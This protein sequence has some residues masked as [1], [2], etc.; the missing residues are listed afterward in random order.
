MKKE[1]LVQLR[2][3]RVKIL[4]SILWIVYVCL[5]QPKSETYLRRN[6]GVVSADVSCFLPYKGAASCNLYFLLDLQFYLIG[7]IFV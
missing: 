5:N 7:D 2:Y 6:V 4:W 1:M 3:Q